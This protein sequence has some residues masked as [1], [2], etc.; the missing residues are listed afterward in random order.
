[1]QLKCNKTAKQMLIAAFFT[2]CGSLVSAQ[3][4]PLVMILGNDSITLSE[5]KNNYT[6]NNSLQ[7]TTEESLRNYINL[8]VNYRLKCNE[9]RQL[10][11]DT[12]KRFKDEL[13]GYRRQAAATYLTEKSVNEK[14]IREA[15]ENCRF[16][17]R[18]WHIMKKLSM[19]PKPEDTLAAYK[20]MLKIR[21]RLL[22]GEKFADL[23][24]AESD[25]PSARPS[26]KDGKMVRAGNTGDLGYFT[27]FSMV[28][29]FE[30]A[31]YNT[32]VGE[33]S[34][35]VRSNFGYHLIY[36]QD[37]Q[38]AVNQFTTM[39]ILIAYP[40]NA[41][42]EDSA[43][44]RK[45]VQE[46]YEALQN[47]MTFEE[48]VEK[49]C[50]DDGLRL[51]K[52]EMDPFRPDRFEGDFVAPLYQASLGQVIKPFET[53]YGWHIVKLVGKEPLVI[54]EN[55][56]GTIKM[57]VA[58]DNRSNL[59]PEAMVER[60]KKEYNFTEAKS[61]K[62]PSPLAEFYSIDSTAIFN[63]E[64]K[65][66]EFN[67][68][69]LMFSFA[70]KKYTQQDFASYIEKNQFKGMR[71]I[72]MRELIDYAYNRFVYTTIFNYENEHLEAKYP[73]FQALMN[74]Y[75]D[76]IMLY[77]LNNERVWKKSETDTIG[78]INFYEQVKEDY[79]YP[80]R[81]H[82]FTYTLG[83]QKSYQLF[84]KLMK[85]GYGLDD[86]NKKFSKK[87]WLI[88]GRENYYAQGE[89]KEFDNICPWIILLQQQNLV[90]EKPEKLQ[91]ITVEK[92]DP[93]PR[94]ISEVRGLVIS[95]Y[96]NL[97]EEQWI[98]E[99]RQDNRIWIDEDTIM[100]LIRK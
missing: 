25:D 54:D 65:A 39:Q 77:E 51:R 15:M 32:K 35:P 52:G 60:L 72:A 61:K 9:A 64:W 97:L 7:N 92:T 96:Q 91:Y 53:R 75:E 40:E 41:T 23:A 4:D 13:K 69:K 22:K 63:G 6:K 98:K 18:A 36:V 70:D 62:Q 67:G 68:N 94:P 2:L 57:K 95:R 74:E 37:K 44:T 89:N 56:Q 90:I 14:L 58:R 80:V 20:E 84:T 76:G 79:M 49:Y 93:T 27:A 34:M 99:L 48:A 81:A 19:E 24:F 11:M 59:G 12:V 5:F 17:I 8:Y 87:G 45:K 30:K 38:P 16:D 1:M 86:I 33:I 85:K 88:S 31:A 42:A 29:E 26:Y 66:S 10:H 21:N 71:K 78:L 28:Y 82:V 55:T 47:G 46:A 83:D 100:T 43:A 73:E 50:T 3:T